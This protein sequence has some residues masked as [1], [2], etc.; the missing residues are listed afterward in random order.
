MVSKLDWGGDRK[1]LLKLY[2]SLIRSKLDYGSIVYGSARKSYLQ[3]LEPIANQGLRLALGAFRTSPVESLRAEANEPSLTLRREKLSVQYALRVS[4]NKGNPTHD[5]VFNPKYQHLFEAKPNAIPTFG[6]RV[7]PIL[8]EIQFDASGVVPVGPSQTPPW[9]VQT[10]QVI[11][12]LA[13]HK[14]AGTSP[15]IFHSKFLEISSLTGFISA[16]C[17]ISPIAP[18]S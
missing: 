3:M 9:Q 13:Q 4:A 6:I 15:E 10:P 11:L 7:K 16:L 2:R 1:V 12:D 8:N 5:C 14:K 18:S 17:S